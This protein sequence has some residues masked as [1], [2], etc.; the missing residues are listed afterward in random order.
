MQAAVAV[1]A[2]LATFALFGVGL[3]LGRIFASA[4]EAIGRNPSS[5]KELFNLTILGGS[6]TESVALLAFAV[7][8]VLIV[9][10]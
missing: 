4:N 7:A 10:G 1:G 2:S 8:M 6:M 3:G 5:R 9:R